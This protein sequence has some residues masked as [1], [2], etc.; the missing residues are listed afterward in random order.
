VR[1]G[2]GFTGDA[3]PSIMTAQIHVDG[4]ADV[5]R[6]PARSRR[7]PSAVRH[8]ATPAIPRMV[9]RGGGCR[10]LDACGC[11]TAEGAVVVE[12]DVD[13]GDA[14]GANLVD[15]V[16]EAVA[17]RLIAALGGHALLR[18]LTNLPLRPHPWVRLRGH[19]RR[20]RWRRGRR[21]H[22]PRQPV[23]RARSRARG[24]PQQ[25]HHE[26][27]RRRRGGA[28]P[29]L[30]RLEAGAHG[31]AARDGRYRPLAVWRRTETASRRDRA[32]AGGRAPWSAAA[33]RHRACARPSS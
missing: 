17:P 7:S 14:M 9:A 19:R 24:D 20:G 23:R 32:A 27:H 31:F 29:G 22:R 12:V 21:R 1:L 30:A 13:V 28:G 16:A 2:G 26:R 33:P 18:I 3:D 8:W 15:T 25:G 6:A 10:D 11:S 4:V 5:D